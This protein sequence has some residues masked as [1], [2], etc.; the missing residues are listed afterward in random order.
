M[1][2]TWAFVSLSLLI[3]KMRLNEMTLRALWAAEVL[4]FDLVT[5][6]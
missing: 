4:G 3:C 2:K 1:E 6:R 5:E